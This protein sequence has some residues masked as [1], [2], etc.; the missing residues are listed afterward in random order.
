MP[1]DEVVRIRTGE[2]GRTPSV[3]EA[4]RWSAG[5]RRGGKSATTLCGSQQEDEYET[6][7]NSI[8]VMEAHKSGDGGFQVPRFPR[9]L[10]A[11][12]RA[13][14]V[15]GGG[16][17]EEGLGFDGLSIRGWQPINAPTCW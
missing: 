2:R 1:I 12:H 3:G 7:K 6:P 8:K 5:A 4:D 13:A 11:H 10:A 16:G 9:H 15:L 17:F 14:I